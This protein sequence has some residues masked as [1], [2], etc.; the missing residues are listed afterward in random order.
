MNNFIIPLLLIPLLLFHRTVRRFT[1]AGKVKEAF[2]ALWLV[3]TIFAACGT[4][5]NFSIYQY[6]LTGLPGW[7]SF[8]F[9]VLYVLVTVVFLLITPS[10]FRVF[11]KA[12]P[13]NPD[14]LLRAEYRFNDTFGLVRNFFLVLLITLPLALRL[15]SLHPSLLSAVSP[16]SVTELCS[17]AGFV[18]FLILLPL[19][20]RQ[21]LFWL[22]NLRMPPTEA[23]KKL[24]QN[25]RTQIH[26]K[27]KNHVL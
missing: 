14:D 17:A 2:C 11:C 21:T 6:S 1:A 12:K 25:Y 8:I 4:V 24:L 18:I 15:F 7:Q 22:K 19:C 26:F 13:E 9:V 16:W 5:L 23:E 27:T 10:G 20:L 3:D